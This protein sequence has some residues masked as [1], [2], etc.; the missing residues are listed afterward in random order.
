MQKG[1]IKY[2]HTSLLAGVRFS[3]RQTLGERH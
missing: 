3:P 1:L 2:T